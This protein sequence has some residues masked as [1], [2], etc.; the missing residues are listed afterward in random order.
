MWCSEL[1]FICVNSLD[2][3]MLWDTEG[4]LFLFINHFLQGR[5]SYYI[6]M[7]HFTQYCRTQ[8]LVKSSHR[9]TAIQTEWKCFSLLRG[10]F[11]QNFCLQIQKLHN[12]MFILKIFRCGFCFVKWIHTHIHTNT[13]THTHLYIYIYIYI[14]ILYIYIYIVNE[15]VLIQVLELYDGTEA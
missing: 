1:S 12:K 6:P 5:W 8:Q 13:H 3:S 10:N 4:M 15:Q 11:V 7:Q 2:L 14:Y 9:Q